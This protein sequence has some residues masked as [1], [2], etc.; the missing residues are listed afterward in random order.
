MSDGDGGSP[1]Q[2]PYTA[3]ARTIDWRGAF[4]MGLAAQ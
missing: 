2:V 1:E 3:L 4:V